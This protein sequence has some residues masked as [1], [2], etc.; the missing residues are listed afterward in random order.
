MNSLAGESDNSAQVSA[1]P[2]VNVPLPWMTQD[3][4][5]NGLW[6]S[7]GVTNG[8]FTVNGSGNDIWDS[9][10]T[11]RFVYLTNN[12]NCTIIA[13]VVSVQNSDG[14]AKA[15]IMARDSM[16]PGAANAF[17]A[18]TPG[19]GVTWQYRSSDG[20]GCNNNA[21]SGSA[22]YWVK[23][24]RTGNTFT[25]YSSPNGTSWTQVGSTTL[26]NVTSTAYIGLAVTSHNSS[27]SCAATFDNV[28]GPGWPPAALIV[29]A[30]AASSSQV[31][32]TWNTLTNATS[33]N[34]KRS[35]TSGGP[36]TTIAS[37]L[38]AT[39]YSDSVVS[40]RAGYYYVVSAVIGG[41]E[42]NSPE[43]AVQ[44]LKLTGGI[45]GTAGSW[46]NSGNTITNVFDGD[47]TTFFDAPDPGNG[48]WAG[49]DFGAGVSNVIAQINYCPRSGSESRMVGGVFQ[50]ANNASFTGAVTLFTIANQPAAG[51]FTSVNLTNTAG[52][53][54]VRYLSPS[55]GYGNVA[56]L[57]FTA[58]RG[59][60]R[61]RHR[62]A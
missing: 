11:F 59:P 16:D 19:N 57:E 58:I 52:F 3:I 53:R 7:A 2:T 25:G 40:V 18:V 10:D 14:W 42:T 4:G 5:V 37:G 39:N 55:G 21:T 50:G 44:F 33:Y 26:T 17:I 47:L 34:V 60:L 61:V 45:I 15:G 32:L 35:N 62:P 12:S 30:I 27:S 36:Y 49:L 9:A 1:T 38:T 23:L 31:N 28:S 54:Y 48:D 8:V 43:A 51:V 20:G 24:V 41:G 29:Y 13:R 56:E 46:N 22:P 6:G